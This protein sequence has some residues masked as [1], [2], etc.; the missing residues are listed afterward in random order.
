MILTS[1]R[2]ALSS[3]ASLWGSIGLDTIAGSTIEMRRSNPRSPGENR[4]KPTPCLQVDTSAVQERRLDVAPWSTISGI[5]IV[6]TGG[7]RMADGDQIGKICRISREFEGESV[8]HLVCTRLGLEIPS[9]EYLARYV[10]RCLAT[11]LNSL[12]RIRKLCG[13]K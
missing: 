13:N 1:W 11:L 10:T 2:G 7:R 5:C 8:G 6:V 12:D 4:A 9:G 3:R